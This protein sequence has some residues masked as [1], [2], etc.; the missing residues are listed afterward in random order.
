[1]EEQNL[2]RDTS[3]V[4][5]LEGQNFTIWNILIDAELCTSGSRY[6]CDTD[7]APKSYSTTLAKCDQNNVKALQLILRKLHHKTI[8]S[9]VNAYMV[10]NAKAIWKNINTKYTSQ[11]VTKRGRTWMR[12]ECLYFTG[13]IKE[14]VKEC[15]NIL[16]DVAGI[17]ITI[18]PHLMEYSILEKI[19]R[20][21]DMYDH[22][23]D[24]MVLSMSS[25]INPQ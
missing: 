11:T 12:W 16:F 21:S 25:K 15:S 13:N 18:P 7:L 19:S 9:V 14:Y 8:V 3:H 4:P 6:V 24:S 5:T 17:G 23:I 1:M 20:D 10:K 22:F 2:K